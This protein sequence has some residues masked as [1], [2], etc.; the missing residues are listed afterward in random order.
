LP[1]VVLDGSVIRHGCFSEVFPKDFDK[2]GNGETTMDETTASIQFQPV[3]SI[4]GK[5]VKNYNLKNASIEY[6]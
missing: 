5:W 3:G 2:K 4:P 1:G 6:A